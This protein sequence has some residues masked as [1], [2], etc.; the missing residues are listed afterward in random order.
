MRGNT[1]MITSIDTLPPEV[2]DELDRYTLKAI[3]QYTDTRK[4]K[5]AFKKEA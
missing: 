1:T 3:E 2:I 4:G 5:L